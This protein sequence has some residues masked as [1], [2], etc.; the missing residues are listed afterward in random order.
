MN[1]LLFSS[2]N[3][4]NLKTL[5]AAVRQ[6]IPI[7]HLEIFDN[8]AGLE[9]RL[10]RPIEPYSIAVLSVADRD[11]LLKMQS[12]RKLLP[13]IYVVLVVPDQKKKTLALAHL[14]LPRFLSRNGNDFAD[15]KIVLHK[16]YTNSL[17]SLKE[18][19]VSGE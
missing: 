6:A 19:I 14:L 1:T 9:K 8:L 4:R 10:R 7:R 18:E 15:L 5:E 16:M 11:E 13:E 12:L 3:D 17:R 2:R